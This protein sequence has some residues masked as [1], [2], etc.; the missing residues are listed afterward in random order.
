M[1]ASIKPDGS[2][3]IIYG[4]KYTGINVQSPQNLIADTDA[5]D[6]NN[7][8]V[9]NAQITSRPQ[10]IPWLTSAIGG[11]N[12]L[13]GVG[14]FLSPSRYYHTFA[15]S[16]EG[17][18][19]NLD[20][21]TN[22]LTSLATLSHLQSTNPVSWRVF[23]SIL[24]WVNGSQSMGAWDGQLSAGG[25]ITYGVGAGG[26]GYAVGDTGTVTTGGANATY[27][28]TAVV[29]GAVTAFVITDSGSGYSV[30]NGQATA[31]TTGGGDGT[32]TVNVF[33]IGI[34]PSQDVA[35]VTTTLTGDTNLGAKYID[36]LDQ[37][38][39]L[40]NT[41]GNASDGPFTVRWSAVGLPTV[42]D[43]TVNINAGFNIFI[44][45]ADQ[46]TGFMALGRVGYIFHRTGITEMAPTG[47]GTAPFDFNHIWNSQDGMGNIFPNTVAQYGTVGVFV[48]TDNVYSVSNYQFS[49][50]GGTARDAIFADFNA[51]LTGINNPAPIASIL[52][53]YADDF[54]YLTYQLFIPLSVSGPTVVWEYSF[55]NQTWERF[56]LTGELVT[57]IPTFCLTQ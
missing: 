54:V 19:W 49:P 55:E 8:I 5:V 9:R 46:I 17:K 48:A 53:G 11:T 6:I 47:V 45:F 23:N 22:T 20:P 42:F 39:I 26:T 43:P 7:F 14:S 1:A 38:V 56:T 18:L 28:V 27:Q 13:T 29:G 51:A 40:A 16:S 12:A 57:G 36:V 33:T 44:D 52:P 15:F 10:F 25:I 24:Y 3:E 50:I 31:V 21:S 37:H 32:F 41:V 35:T 4:Q 2:F 34:G 30:S